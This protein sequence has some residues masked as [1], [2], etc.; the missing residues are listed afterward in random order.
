MQNIQ[1]GLLVCWFTYWRKKDGEK[2]GILKNGTLITF[3]IVPQ[4][5][6]QGAHLQIRIEG[7]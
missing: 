2:A 4:L 3:L 1:N 5:E 6:R 7:F